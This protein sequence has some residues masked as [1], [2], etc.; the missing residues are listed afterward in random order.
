MQ[1][2][3]LHPHPSIHPSIN[4][5]LSR[6]QIHHLFLYFRSDREEAFS[7]PSAAVADTYWRTAMQRPGQNGTGYRATI[8]IDRDRRKAR[9]A[10]AGVVVV[11]T[12]RFLFSFF[13]GKSK[14]RY[15]ILLKEEETYNTNLKRNTTWE[16]RTEIN[17]QSD[18]TYRHLK[19]PPK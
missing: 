15:L 2:A 10:A 1:R 16:L 9:H 3:D 11:W 14:K 5:G 8:E 18:N 12:V 4:A 17:C 6:A 7:E 13:L 19:T